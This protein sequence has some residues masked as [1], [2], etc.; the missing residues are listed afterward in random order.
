M[1]ARLLPLAV[2]AAA[3]C[4]STAAQASSVYDECVEARRPIADT[5]RSRSDEILLEHEQ[6][7]NAIIGKFVAKSSPDTDT[8]AYIDRS[9]K[10]ILRYHQ[11]E[12]AEEQLVDDVIE[13]L[14]K[15]QGAEDE[16][17]RC[18]DTSATSNWARRSSARLEGVLEDARE[19]F[20]ER[21][22]F[23]SL[24]KNEG[25]A[26]IAFYAH[27]AVTSARINRLGA[28]TGSIELD[29]PGRGEHVRL[30]KLPA[31]EYE[32]QRLRQEW[33]FSKYFFNL[34]HRDLRFTVFP[35]KLNVTG[36]F[37]YE[38]QGRYA[39]T[40]LNDRPA[41][42]LRLIE[43]RFPELLDRFELANGMVPED[44]FIDVY[45]AEKRSIEAE[46]QRDE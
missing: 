37:I 18:P 25:L 19:D 31:G 42:V 13:Q 46:K 24:K 15:P 1:I 10:S 38:S 30:L 26:I 33:G 7:L 27:G 14:L 11:V 6:A 36:V 32:W 35:G 17:F 3:A 41:I 2:V 4:A 44:R 39:S 21:V 28:L 45:L 20:E 29:L 8:L 12:V 23:E 9:K 43:Q 5:H 22:G 16:D 34:G 40:S